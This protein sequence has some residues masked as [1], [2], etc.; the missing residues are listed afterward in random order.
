[1]KVFG[2]IDN[3]FSNNAPFYMSSTPQYYLGQDIQEWTG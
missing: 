2:K 1:M 3:N